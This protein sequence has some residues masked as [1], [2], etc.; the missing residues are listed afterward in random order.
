MPRIKQY[1][2]KYAEEDF[3]R[4]VRCK[5]GYY[6]LMSMTALS[7]ETGIPR[8]TLAK[9]I[10][11]PAGMS[12]EELR[13]IIAVLHLDPEI[14]LALLGYTTKEINRFENNDHQK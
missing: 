1:A 6:D 3:R 14:S 12:V 4:E 9:R 2:E 7:N 13:K 8:T 10:S 11:I 5:Q